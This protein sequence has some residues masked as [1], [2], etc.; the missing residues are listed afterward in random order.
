ML[1]MK[2]KYSVILRLILTENR[3]FLMHRSIVWM[4]P[5]W[6]VFYSFSVRV[7]GGTSVGGE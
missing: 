4:R 1:Q 3:Q 2:I 5:D 6:G 7:L